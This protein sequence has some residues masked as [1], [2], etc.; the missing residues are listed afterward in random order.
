MLKS[1]QKEVD[2][3]FGMDA[4]YDTFLSA[5][6]ASFEVFFPQDAE[7]DSDPDFPQCRPLHWLEE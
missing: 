6:H 2:A 7:S 3:S 5:S 1:F 4:M